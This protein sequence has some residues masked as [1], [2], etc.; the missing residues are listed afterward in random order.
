MEPLRLA[1]VAT[2]LALVGLNI[3]A[4]IALLSSDELPVRM[5]CGQFLVVW[6]LPGLGA[7]LVLHLLK[8]DQRPIA[9]PRNWDPETREI[10]YA[11][12]RR[13]SHRH[14]YESLGREESSPSPSSMEG[15]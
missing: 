5:K 14:E 11:G 12:T 7:A 6:M 2:A 9:K 1:A 3:K 10:D 8:E 4:T 13:S 15:D